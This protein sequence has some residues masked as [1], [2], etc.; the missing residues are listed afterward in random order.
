MDNKWRD[1]KVMVPCPYQAH[2]H[3]Y[4]YDRYFGE[5][6]LKELVGEGPIHFET[7]THTHW[8]QTGPHNFCRE[9]CMGG[10][11]RLFIE[12]TLT[13]L[14]GPWRMLSSKQ[15]HQSLI[16]CEMQK[17]KPCF[18]SS[19]FGKAKNYFFTFQNCLS[20]NSKP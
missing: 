8:A 2:C 14:L 18:F 15:G 12:L 4:V 1:L 5:G 7:Y 13:Q 6:K 16:M 11:L 9:I 3:V 10:K 20:F 19:S 17:R